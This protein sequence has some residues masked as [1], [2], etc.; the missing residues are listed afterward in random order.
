MQAEIIT[1]GTELLLGEI[2]DSNA[3]WISQQLTT[4]GLNLYY[5]TTVGDNLAR[6][7]HVLREALAR[8]E[9]VITTGGLGPTIDDMT[10]E[11]VAAATDREL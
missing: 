1:I 5:R 11:A 7:T 2:V 6:I 4:I 8:S 9:V 10:R 3:A